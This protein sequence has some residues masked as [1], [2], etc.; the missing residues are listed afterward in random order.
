MSDTS[1]WENP[2][3]GTYR[4]RILRPTFGD[5]ETGQGSFE[6]D[7][8]GR[9]GFGPDLRDP[10]DPEVSRIEIL[11]RSSRVAAIRYH[12]KDKVLM[13]TWRNGKT[14][15]IYEG[16]PLT[17]YSEMISADSVGKYINMVLHGGAKS[18]GAFPGRPVFS[19]D[20]YAEYIYGEM[21]NA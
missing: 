4:G 9:G 8:T 13:V 3:Q 6:L 18:G 1:S 21:L 16:V 20:P 14:P 2:F 12:F 17:M 11:P 19:S 5:P 7:I 10:K 15:Y